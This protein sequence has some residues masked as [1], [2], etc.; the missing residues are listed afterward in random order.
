[1]LSIE[2]AIQAVISQTRPLSSIECPTVKSLGMVLAE[3]ITADV[4]S[5][6]HDKALVDGFAVQLADLQDLSKTDGLQIVERITAG[7]I[8]TKPVSPGYAAQ[9]MTGAPI[10]VGAQAMI[11]VEQTEVRN[12]AVHYHGGEVTSGQGI[13]R[14]AS[15]FAQGD[16]V[17]PVRTVVRPIEIGLLSEVGRAT[18]RCFA[19]P[20]VSVLPTGEELVSADEKPGPGQIRNSN[21]PML[22][23]LAMAA[24]C[25]T[26]LLDAARDNQDDLSDKISRG[27]QSDV[28]I[29][30]GGVS[31]GV[32]DLVPPTLE[33]QGVDC[34]FHKVSLKPGKPIWFG[35]REQSG[36]RTLVF[37]LPGNPVSSLA[38]FELFVK[39]AIQGLSG[40]S[41][42]V[43]WQPIR[44]ANDF[45]TRG[46]RPTLLARD[47]ASGSGASLC[48]ALAMA[49]F[50]RHAD[51][52]AGGLFR[53]FFDRSPH[54][55]SGGRKAACTRDQIVCHR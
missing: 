34:V 7:D 19:A 44:L 49:R 29:L 4:D 39:T 45:Q 14:R 17:L 47:F 6:P 24:G 11:M 16:I 30:S 36:H 21:G 27:L 55:L 9:V 40:R 31:A 20:Q 50:G 35:V 1:M 37:G 52:H 10:P 41:P 43:P 51:R 53:I 28:L 38:C 8:P 13:I 48:G 32:R 54:S 12:N 2:E 26:Q 5:P 25:E 15:I 46:N 42:L 18:V 22:R 3:E 23:S 33:S